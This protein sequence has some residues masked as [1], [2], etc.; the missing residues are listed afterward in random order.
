MDRHRQIALPRQAELIGEDLDLHSA[1]GIHVVIIETALPNPDDARRVEPGFEFAATVQVE[2]ARLVGVD[3]H[4]CK[5]AG[6]RRRQGD[7]ARVVLD[8]IARANGDHGVD[9][10]LGCPVEHVG[11]I[12]CECIG[13]DVAVAVEPHG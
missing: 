9:A 2:L 6:I 13:A 11:A 12:F 7:S 5:D 8:A 4:R 10:P 3:A 1:V